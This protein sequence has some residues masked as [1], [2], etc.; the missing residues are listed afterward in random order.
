VAT[1]AAMFLA[2]NWPLRLLALVVNPVAIGMLFVIGH[3]ACHNSLTSIGWL[4]RILGRIVFLPAY[5]PY[6]SWVHAHNTLHHGWTNFKGRHPDFS[7]FTLDEFARLPAWRRALERIYRTPLGI[8]LYY[9]IDFWLAHLLFPSGANRPAYRITF[10]LDRVLVG[11]FLL[12]QL[13]L[14]W[15]LAAGVSADP[16]WCAAYAAGAVATAFLLWIWFMGFVSFIQHTHPRMAWYDNEDEWS[17]YH[18]QLRSTAHVVFPWPIEHL[19]HNIMDHPAH[20]LD[21]QIPL[22]RLPQAQK[23]LEETAAEHAVV[24]RWTPLDYWRTCAACK[25][26]DF[27]RHCWTDFAGVPTTPCNL[28]ELPVPAADTLCCSAQK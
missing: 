19:L 28:P 3:D 14:A 21:P 5:H 20:H 23:A 27:D 15:L 7:P 10:F 24:I 9:T 26:Y 4:N 13:G 11:V 18:V 25:L 2:P 17:F 6:T 16:L 1:F 22:Y 8:G 12:A